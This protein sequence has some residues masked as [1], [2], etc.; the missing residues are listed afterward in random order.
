MTQRLTEDQIETAARLLKEGEVISFATETVYGLGAPIFNPL[1]IEQIFKLKG[2]PSDN[3]LIAHLSHIEEVER[4]AVDIPSTFYHLAH[5]F[6]PGP[7][8]LVLKKHP[9]VPSI[10]SGGLETIALRLP[11]H[12]VA[13]KLIA[14]VGE[15]VVAPSANLSGRP[16]ATCAEHVLEDFEGKIAAVLDGGRTSLGIESTVLSLIDEVPTLLRPGVISKEQIEEVLGMSIAVA[17]SKTGEGPLLSP[18]MKYRHYS[19]TTPIRVFWDEEELDCYLSSCSTE[20][21][22]L[23]SPVNKEK[24]SCFSLNAKDFYASLRQADREGFDEILIFCNESVQRDAGLMNR[25][26][27]AAG[28]TERGLL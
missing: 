2:R 10:V 3:P 23:L 19:P 24:A 7:L 26:L 28:Y 8:T 13:Q 1:A 21:I 12:P 18:G 14:L 17:S 11:S 16:S 9:S 20:R 22:M 5:V 27:K 4:I 15:P 25:L 6:F